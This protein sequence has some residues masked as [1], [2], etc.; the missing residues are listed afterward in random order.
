MP[1]KN[2]EEKAIPILIPKLG[3][4]STNPIEINFIEAMA[5][6]KNSRNVLIRM[7]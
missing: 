5:M 4:F 7:A 1:N 6:I 3:E 2:I